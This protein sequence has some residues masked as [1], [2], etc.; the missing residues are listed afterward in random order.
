MLE[1]DTFVCKDVPV[2]CLSD[3]SCN[4]LIQA[5]AYDWPRGLWSCTPNDAGIAVLVGCVAN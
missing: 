4:C 3:A 1:G 2:A 5:Q